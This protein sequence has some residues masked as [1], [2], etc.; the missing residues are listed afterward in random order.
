ME[1]SQESSQS[2]TSPNNTTAEALTEA[3]T[4]TPRRVRVLFDYF[5]VLLSF[6]YILGTIMN[7]LVLAALLK[8]RKLMRAPFYIIIAGL[9][10]SECLGG[11]ATPLRLI[12]NF[13]DNIPFKLFC[14]I[15]EAV[16]M[17]V[18]YLN[19][20][21]LLVISVERICA[22]R[23]PVFYKN[24]VTPRKVIVFLA[25]SWGF[26]S[27]VIALVMTS[28]ETICFVAHRRKQRKLITFPGL[29]SRWA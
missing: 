28:G 14:I 4:I 15:Y 18:V 16:F 27:V 7:G 23:F 9:C 3:I 5:V 8:S 29:I 21:N 17:M 6:E 12:T 22:V 26:Y 1:P 19:N 24:R 13:A 10:L 25:L 20:Y 11:I 2:P